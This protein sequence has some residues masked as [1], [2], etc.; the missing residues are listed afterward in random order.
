[1]NVAT[2]LKNRK[3]GVIA[4]RPEDTIET[5]ANMLSSNKIGAMPVRDAERNL[6]GIISERDIICGFT[7]KGFTVLK[8]TV[9]DW[10]TSH[11]VVC[12]LETTVKEALVLMNKRGCRHLPVVEGGELVGIIS[13]R[14]VMKQKLEISKLEANV[15]RDHIIAARHS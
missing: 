11:V 8:A 2:L 13:I 5:A 14:D 1:M 15:L 12:H 6:I 10:M 4:C 3:T 9:A 7:S